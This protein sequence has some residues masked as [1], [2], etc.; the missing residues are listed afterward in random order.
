MNQSTKQRIVGTLVLL[1]AALVLLPVLLD[2]EG[3]YR[4]PLESRI[5]SPPPFEE[6][7][8]VIP[9]RPVILADGSRS[10]AGTDAPEAADASGADAPTA[11]STSGAAPDGQAAADPSLLTSPLT[12]EEAPE[13]NVA[14]TDTSN[15]V[16]DP[17]AIALA[18]VA[19]RGNPPLDNQGLPRGWS[20]RLGVF[21]DSANAT[22][23]V[24]RLKA[25]EHRAYS[26]PTTSSNGPATAVYVGPQIDRASAEQLLEQLRT[27]FQLNGLIVPFEI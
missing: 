10:A 26:R 19:S 18:E 9:E 20:V 2:G 8:R 14:A 27:D 21:A 11:E 4:T 7:A 23:L 13:G 25:S 24:E 12:S 6:P 15:A 1:I 3:S 22:A 17:V 16:A 5:P